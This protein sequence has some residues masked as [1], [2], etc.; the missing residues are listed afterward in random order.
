M[1]VIPE[2]TVLTKI[3]SLALLTDSVG[4]WMRVWAE[5]AYELRT[6]VC[7]TVRRTKLRPACRDAL[8]L[9]HYV[10]I[11]LIMCVNMQVHTYILVTT[12]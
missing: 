10:E 11:E 9:L 1:Y 3:Q 8:L 6:A 4:G 2:V 12:L 5:Y 7:R